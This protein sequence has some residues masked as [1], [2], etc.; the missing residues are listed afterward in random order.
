MEFQG[1]QGY[2]VRPCL[3]RTNYSKFFVL[4]QTVRNFSGETSMT[5]SKNINWE[6]G[7]HKSCGSGSVS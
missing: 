3:E 5:L 4:F 2:I 7:K 1:S 6:V